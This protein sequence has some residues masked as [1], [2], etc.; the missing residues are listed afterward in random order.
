VTEDECTRIVYARAGL[1]DPAMAR[2]E[3][4][5]A[6]SP[7]SRQH[8]VKRSH[9]GSWDPRNIVILCGDGTTGCHGWAE[10]H[11]TEA[12][13]A[14]WAYKPGQALGVR[15]IPHHFLGPVWLL[16]DGGYSYG[17]PE[18]AGPDLARMVEDLRAPLPWPPHPATRPP[19]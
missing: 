2:C 11:P 6:A 12:E 3:K 19:R 4:C 8:L 5:G 7:L 1:G 16:A 17:P 10:H 18:E 13:A 9:G 14:G 15:P